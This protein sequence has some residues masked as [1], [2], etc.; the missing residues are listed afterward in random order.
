MKAAAPAHNTVAKIAEDNNRPHAKI[1]S[2]TPNNVDKESG[3]QCKLLMNDACEFIEEMYDWERD[4][5]LEYI[6]ENSLN[7]FVYIKYTWKQLGLSEAWYRQ[8]CR[9][10]LND[11][12]TINRE[13]NLA[14]TKSSDN[15]VFNEEDLLTM[16]SMLKHKSSKYKVEFK[17]FV[18]YSQEF[19]TH[20]YF[21]NLYK[22]LDPNKK[23]FI[24]CDVAAGLSKDRSTIVITD[25]EDDFTPVGFFRSATINIELFAHLLRVLVKEHIPKSILFIENNNLGNAV[26]TNLI[27]Y[28]PKNIFFSY[29]V[30]DK[31]KG[32]N[33]A[34]QTD[35]I[36]LG[37]NTNS[38]S[39]DVMFD[40]LKDI[41]SNHPQQIAFKEIYDEIKNLAYIKG[42]IDHEPGHHDDIIMGYLMVRYS[43]E[44]GNS[45]G[46][47]LGK[48]LDPNTVN[49]VL[50]KTGAQ[51][52]GNRVEGNK[53]DLFKIQ[54]LLIL[55]AE[56]YSPEEA[57]KILIS[58]G[59]V[60][61]H[62]SK[63]KSVNYNILH[64]VL[65]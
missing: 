35:N 4:K 53:S 36:I 10:L 3:L 8:Q 31:Q 18:A 11:M 56:G 63:A 32:K 60:K 58:K 12:L 22:P 26:I 24:G 27:D 37:V 19:H 21:L 64:D 34:T 45:I 46:R 52:I 55:T 48:K 29:R 16:E 59:S 9:D 14:W 50:S 38:S 20:T 15:S 30:Q 6:A 61:N 1:I 5:V 49:T 42:R 2:T 62:D 44:T 39:R 33:P 25:P 43:V 17:R 57:M 7:D 23:Y 65:N 40:I 41:V 51:S 54:D 47:F 28:I 13:I